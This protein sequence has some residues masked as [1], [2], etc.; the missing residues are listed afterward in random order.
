MGVVSAVVVSAGVVSA[1]V[2]TVVSSTVVGA[3]VVSAG[4]VPQAVIPSTIVPAIS[5]AIS[6]FFIFHSSFLWAVCPI[7]CYLNDTPKLMHRSTKLSRL[8]VPFT[9]DFTELI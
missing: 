3:T 8:T 7:G 9:V 4:F 1:V 2:S 6:V 5:V